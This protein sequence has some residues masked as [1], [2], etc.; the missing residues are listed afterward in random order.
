MAKSKRV[1][2]LAG[3]RNHLH[4]HP[5]LRKG[6]SHQ[7]STKSKRCSDKVNLKREW[8]QVSATPFTCGH[9]ASSHFS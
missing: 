7:Q 9:F 1:T 2:G 6:G 4:N 3:T 5:L 8:P